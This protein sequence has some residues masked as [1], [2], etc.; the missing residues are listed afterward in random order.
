MVGPRT[1]NY[2]IWQLLERTQRALFNIRSKEVSRFGVSLRGAGVLS[3]VLRLGE[4]ATPM[5]I[6]RQ[7]Y[8]SPNSISEQLKRM[9]KEGLIRKVKDLK[10]KNQV[11]IE[12]TEKGYEIYLN[13]INLPSIEE[14]VSVLTHDEKMELWRLLSKLRKSAIEKQG[15]EDVVPYY[16][17]TVEELLASEHGDYAS[18]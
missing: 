13:V 9:E 7:S 8:V 1:I 17:S 2:H 12:V 3:I 10:K 11:R 15:I 16:P 14:T 5:A 4:K 18:Q 6:S